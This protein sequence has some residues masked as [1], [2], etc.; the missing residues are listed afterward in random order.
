V[1]QLSDIATFIHNFRVEG[2]DAARVLPTTIVVGN[3][4]AGEAAFRSR[5]AGCHSAAGDLRGFGAKFAD[6]R[7]LQQ[8]WLMPTAGRGRGGAP[9]SNV[10][11]TTATV[12]LPSGQT[13]TGRL[14]RIDDFLVTL[15]QADGTSRSFT[16]TGDSPK[17]EIADPLK[18]HRDL[19]PK[20]TDKEIHDITAYL[21]TLK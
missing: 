12:T 21:V 16:R 5:C 7:D 4:T 10:P 13:V 20:Y 2:Y 9:L 19:L 15:E 6:A 14:R 18:P 3:A 1:A 8:M 11:P 17:V